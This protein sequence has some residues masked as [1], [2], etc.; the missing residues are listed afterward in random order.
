[1]GLRRTY[2]AEKA[3]LLG[4][5]K[6]ATPAVSAAPPPGPVRKYLDATRGFANPAL[7]SALLRQAGGLRVKPG[8][9]LIPFESEQ[10]Y[11]L[12][13]PG[14]VWFAKARLAPFISLLARDA[15]VDG[16]GNMVVALPGGIRVVDARGA[17]I[18]QG[19]ALRYWG[20]IEAFP[21]AAAAMRWEAVDNARAR[22]TVEDDG[23]RIGALVEFDAGGFPFATHADRYRDVGGGKAE[24]TAW[25][26]YFAEWKSLGGRAFPTRWESVWHLPGGDFPAVRMEILRVESRP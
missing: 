2:E 4:R 16:K 7:T 18:D 23:L 21:D 22:F 1:V 3:A 11:T 17:Q 19:A 25:S 26:G 20:E 13:P 8:G 14:F 9:R 15:F 10:V 5:A 6:G 24:L 12:C